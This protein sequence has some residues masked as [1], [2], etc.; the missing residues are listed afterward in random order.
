[1]AESSI[2]RIK[3]LDKERARLLDSAKKEALS[4]AEQAVADLNALGF[5][6]RLV[7]SIGRAKTARA[8]RGGTRTIKDKVCPVCDFKTKPPHDRRAHRFSKAKKRP[9]TAAEL[10]EKGYVR[11]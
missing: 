7:N 1:M 10:K 3:E 9:F 11:V 5:A 2:E 4:R 6:Y 8:S